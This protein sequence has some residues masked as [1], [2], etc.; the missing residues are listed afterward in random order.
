[1]NKT[2]NSILAKV[3]LITSW[4]KVVLYQL[5]HFRNYIN[6]QNWSAKVNLSGFYSLPASELRVQI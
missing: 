1:M 5:N 2:G 3:V 4:G 6:E